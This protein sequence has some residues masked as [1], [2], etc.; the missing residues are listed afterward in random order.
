MSVDPGSLE[1]LSSLEGSEEGGIVGGIVVKKKKGE[2]SGSMDQVV[3][4][5]TPANGKSQLAGVITPH[6]PVVS[7]LWS[8]METYQ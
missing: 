6:R 5:D 1:Q 8:P 7:S 3:V 4:I 2:F